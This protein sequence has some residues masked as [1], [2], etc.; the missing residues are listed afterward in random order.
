V[1]TTRALGRPRSAAAHQTILETTI[2][3]LAERGFAGF[4]IVEVAERAGVSTA[5]IYR[6]WPA[7]TPL[8]LEALGTVIL[9]AAIPDTGSTRGDLIAFL[10]ERIIT[11]RGPIF[12]QVIP[13]LAAAGAR[14]PELAASFHAVQAP[15]RAAAFAI[16]ARGIARGDLPENLDQELALDLLLG[17]ITY[18]LLVSGV[19]FDDTL[20]EPIV[21]AVLHGIATAQ[22]EG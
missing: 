5:T 1:T 7:K 11:A 4:T 19:A 22:K 10:H 21:A 14:D 13:A 9:P 3:V 2:R 6:R 15:A 17:P 16:F 12:T 8:I 18:R 20:A